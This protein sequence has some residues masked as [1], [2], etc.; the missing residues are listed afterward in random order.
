MKTEL[1]N[2]SYVLLQALSRRIH[3][4]KF[5]AEVKFKDA[6]EEYGTAIRDQV[7]WG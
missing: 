3:Y 5:V 7:I 4:G 1:R 2:Q 6:P